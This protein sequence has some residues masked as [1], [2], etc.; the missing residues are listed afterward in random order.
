M[1]PPTGHPPHFELVPSGGYRLSNVDERG[2]EFESSL[3]KPYVG[4]LK[5][6]VVLPTLWTLVTFSAKK[7]VRPE[8]KTE[9]CRHNPAKIA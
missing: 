3:V 1:T 6:Q 7:E 4:Q 8:G 5:T 2:A 9:R